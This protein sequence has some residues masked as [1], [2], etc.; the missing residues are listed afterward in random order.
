MDS[1]HRGSVLHYGFP[2]DLVFI[3]FMS[4]WHLKSHAN[5]LFVQQLIQAKNKKTP[6]ST[7]LTLQKGNPWETSGFPSQRASDVAS[8]SMLWCH[9][10]EPIIQKCLPWDFHLL[11]GGYDVSL[12]QIH[13][14]SPSQGRSVPS[15]RQLAKIQLC[16]YI[17]EPC[18][19]P[20]LLSK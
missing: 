8:I 4:V 9:H 6:T 20:G 1:L 15:C 18:Y 19:V 16:N 3:M 13:L 2:C 7:S 10:G 17:Q 14:S 11:N 5:E 12:W